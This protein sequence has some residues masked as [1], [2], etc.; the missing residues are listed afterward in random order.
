MLLILEILNQD[1]AQE[2][3]NVSSLKFTVQEIALEDIIEVSRFCS[4]VSFELTKR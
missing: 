2:I 3:E 4:K 1:R